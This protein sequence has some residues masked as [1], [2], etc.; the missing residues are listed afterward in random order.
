MYDTAQDYAAFETTLAGEAAD[1]FPSGATVHVARAPGRLDVMGGIAD[2][3]GSLVAE[4]PIE[5][6]AMVGALVG[7]TG[8]NTVVVRS[9]NAKA[10]GLTEEVSLPAE[11]FINPV[12]L[13]KYLREHPPEAHWVGYV[14]GCFSLLRAEGLIPRGVGA[15][16]L[17]NSTVP[18]G[19]GVSSSAAVEVASMRALC[20][21]FSV[22]LDGLEMAKLCQRVEND[23]MDAPC[24][25]M[26]QVTATLGEAGKLLLLLCQPAEL[27]G[28]AELP[29]DWCAFGLDSGHKHSVAGNAYIRV[30]VAAFMG[31]KILSDAAKSGFGGYLG[32]VT[33]DDYRRIVA[34]LPGGALPDRIT[35]AE[36]LARHSG[37]FDTVTTVDPN[38]TYLVRAATEHPIFEHERVRD[39]VERIRVGDADPDAFAA[40]GQ[41]MYEAHQSY[42]DCGIGSTETDLLVELA[43][44]QEGVAGAKITGGG[45]GGTV[46][47]LCR[48]D[49]EAAV[50]EAIR[51]AYFRRTGIPARLIR[52]TS[53]GSLA[54]PIRTLPIR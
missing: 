40:A 9:L 43:R 46:C 19:A 37:I 49:R 13:L 35:G 12:S 52:G 32:N 11:V 45:S 33:P 41:R 48:A 1:F 5:Q 15:K 26:D 17:L 28:F 34:N 53:P 8:E 42:T 50:T 23:V 10:E 29:P 51:N 6:A 21:A 3:S 2:Y 25:I 7:G 16:L 31:Y 22:A 30:R 44:E 20:A 14:A 54:T 27:R 39:F 24:G 18:L 36:F 38:E 4:M 47:I